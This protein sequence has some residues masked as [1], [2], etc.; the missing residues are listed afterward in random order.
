MFGLGSVKIAGT[1]SA[2]ENYHRLMTP[3]GLQGSFQNQVFGS[4]NID[5]DQL[6][7]HVVG[8]DAVECFHLYI[9]LFNIGMACC[10]FP[11]FDSTVGRSIFYILEG[12][13]ATLVA[14]REGEY[15]CPSRKLLL[16]LLKHRWNRLETNVMTQWGQLDDGFKYLAFVATHIKG[17][18][19][20]LQYL[21]QHFL[22]QAIVFQVLGNVG[23]QSYQHV[24]YHI[25]QV[26]FSNFMGLLI[27]I[28]GRP[29]SEAANIRHSCGW[30][31]CRMYFIVDACGAIVWQG[32]SLF[33]IFA[34]FIK[35]RF[36]ISISNVSIHFTGENLF[37]GVSFVI[38][39]RDRI[40]LTG[41]NGAGKTTLL[42][43]LAGHL[44]PETGQV[45]RHG[46]CTLGYL[47]QELVP[48]T[49][50]TVLDEAM[51]AFDLILAKIALRDSLVASLS[52]RTDYES[53]GYM[54]LLHRIDEANQ[55]IDIH[56]ADSLE[57]SARRVLEGL[58]FDAADHQ[59]LMSEFSSGWQMRVELAKILLRRPDVILLDEPTNHLDIESIGWLEDWLRSYSGAVVLVSHDRAFLDNV[60][61]RTIEINM[62]RAWDY[63]AGY[64]EYVLMRQERMESQLA[65]LENQQRQVEQIERFIERFRYK[66]TK[67]RQVQSR[68]K[69]LEKI[70]RVEVDETDTSA[71]HFSFPAAPSSGRVVVEVENLSKRYGDLLVLD[72]ISLTIQR[73]E[74]VALVGRN[75]EGKTTLSRIVIGELDCEGRMVTGHNVSI[76]YY[77]QNQA[78]MLDGTKTVF[79]TLDEIAVGDIRTRTRAIL[80][81]FLFSGEAIE[82][83][84]SVLSGGE[85]S[86]LA[87]AKL[88]LKP[89]NLLV[90]DEPT[91]HLDMVSKD[92]LKNALLQYDGT[93]VVVS[94][95]RDFLQGLT[96]KV[97]EFRNKKVKEY[98][99]DVYDFLEAR[100][101][102]HLRDLEQPSRKTT[103][104]IDSAEFTTGKTDY[105][106][107]KAQEREKRKLANRIEQAEN[108]IMQLESQIEQHDN[109]MA[110]PDKFPGVMND[111]SFFDRYRSLKNELEQ[112]TSEWENLVEQQ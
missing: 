39:D 48:P 24:A 22:C 16:Q 85:K 54:Q 91:N 95:D 27:S 92:I 33:R 11:F 65:A 41:K 23:V 56:G 88:L 49:H 84:V 63:K 86:R 110:N 17:I 109:M 18:S 9:D 103:G 64:S 47:S 14:Q 26:H 83:K 40:G 1:Q 100:R 107:R 59:R 82:K 53:E 62:G 67:S 25:L 19:T 111:Q 93:L 102:A 68:V 38:A 44:V 106:Q 5:F 74:K 2:L 7:S 81:S 97:V 94:H 104:S 52:E 79:E 32:C 35:P 20:I 55:Y 66:A 46:D 50:R 101:I 43:I 60:T 108:R 99:G 76:G 90:L 61:N 8:N 80:G 77:A 34:P 30:L 15:G 72:Q 89:V 13:L 28:S 69:M 87:L 31:F 10:I 96:S 51:Q 98:P 42:N 71:I 57:G 12:G 3:E 75:G 112:A 78:Q 37:D 29:V 105:E 6:N 36:M 45:T 58:G 70:E 73:G 21:L 4:F